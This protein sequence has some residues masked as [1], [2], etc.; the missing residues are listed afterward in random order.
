MYTLS[1]SV[2]HAAKTSTYAKLNAFAAG[3]SSVLVLARLYFPFSES[4]APSFAL[5]VAVAILLLVYVVSLLV[6]LLQT[7]RQPE[8]YRGAHLIIGASLV[9]F[10]SFVLRVFIVPNYP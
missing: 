9:L 6:F 4:A 1:K 8:A 3:S 10:S 2:Q 7:H 5:N